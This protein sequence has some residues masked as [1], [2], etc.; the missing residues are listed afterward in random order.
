MTLAIL[1]CRAST[2]KQEDSVP[3]QR[4]WAERAAKQHGLTVL[5]EFSDE[6]IPG[7]EIALRPGLQA[8]LHFVEERCGQ[9]KAVPVLLCYDPDRISRASSIRTGAIL[10][11]LLDAGTTRIVTHEGTIDLQEDTDLLLYNLKQDTAKAAYSK[12]LSSRV[13]AAM[14][15]KAQ[16]GQWAGGPL[17]FGYRVGP[18]GHLKPEPV[19]AEIVLSLFTSYADSATSIKSLALQLNQSGAPLPPKCRAGK[20]IPW[21]VWNLL[22][23][24]VYTGNAYYARR[25][26]G[27]YNRVKVGGVERTRGSRSKTGRLKQEKNDPQDWVIV[28]N[29]HPAIVGAELFAAVQEKL[30]AARLDVEVGKRRRV[31][32]DWPLAGLCRCGDCQGRMTGMK[33]PVGRKKVAYV[34]KMG[35]QTYRDC[36][37]TVCSQNAVPEA[38]VLEAVFEVIREQF[39][40]RDNLKQLR[41]ELKAQKSKGV[42]TTA[43]ECSALAARIA[44][45]SK[46]I[47]GATDR[48]AMIDLP[49]DV[50]QDVVDKI[51][52]W[53]ADRSDAELQLRTLEEET[54]TVK[55]QDD[56]IEGAL[57]AFERLGELVREAH[58]LPEVRDALHALVE[59]IE[60]HFEQRE[61]G[62]RRVSTCAAVTVH[63]RSLGEFLPASCRPLGEVRPCPSSRRRARDRANRRECE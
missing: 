21:T 25:R 51:H 2:K 26:L 47:K 35:C 61:A 45:L 5:R 37:R 19:E 48:I 29:A 32:A 11:R 8:L 40:D 53:K 63:W 27:K 1:Y 34:R 10:T 62:T 18:D 33:V 16:S 54:A 57:A 15:R 38:D 44:E 55:R 59:K 42:D 20:W 12:L 43:K 56:D 50:L 17:P 24:P 28:E 49:A 4:E 41:K 7:D 58:D 46:R 39:S 23:N 52:G 9:G 14:L 13:S 36:G 31:K 30:K 6:G 22:R 60:L 3:L